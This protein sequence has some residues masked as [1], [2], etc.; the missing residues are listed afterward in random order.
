MTHDYKRHG[1]A[2][3]N[4]LDGT[5]IGQYQQRHHHIEWLKFLRQID[6]ETQKDK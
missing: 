6:R 5:V 4:V 3:R 1:I 2:A